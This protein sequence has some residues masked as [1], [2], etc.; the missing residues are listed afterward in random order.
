LAE[1][2]CAPPCLYKMIWHADIHTQYM[3]G[4]LYIYTGVH[5]IIIKASS[6]HTDSLCPEASRSAQGS[7][8]NAPP[9]PTTASSR[10]RA[11]AAQEMAGIWEPFVTAT[12]NTSGTMG[13]KNGNL[14]GKIASLPYGYV[15]HVPTYTTLEQPCLLGPNCPKGEMR[16]MTDGL[17]NP[18]TKG[19]HCELL[20]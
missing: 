12:L 20:S 3:I 6:D 5:Q 8:I 7:T 15:Y 16:S 17:I 1:K 14:R 11:S 18:C 4:L 9:T 2:T 10:F 19:V 13:G